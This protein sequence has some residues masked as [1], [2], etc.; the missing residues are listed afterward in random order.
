M[1]RTPNSKAGPVVR[2][3]IC[4]PPDVAARLEAYSKKRGCP[5]SWA[6]EKLIT[7]YLEKLP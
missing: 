3:S 2:F 5:K 7:R 6:I 1:T 4:L